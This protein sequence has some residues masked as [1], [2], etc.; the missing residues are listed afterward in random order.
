MTEEV[1]MTRKTFSLR[2][3]PEILTKIEEHRRRLQGQSPSAVSVSLRAALED[4][5]MKGLEVAR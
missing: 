1:A 5:V 2:I 3:D 4:L